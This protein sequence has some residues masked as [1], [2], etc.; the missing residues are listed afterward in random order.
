MLIDWIKIVVWFIV[1]NFVCTHIWTEP[2]WY[3]WIILVVNLIISFIMV[4]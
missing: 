2:K 3:W 4:D 1:L